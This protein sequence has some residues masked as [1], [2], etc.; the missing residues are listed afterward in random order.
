MYPS[1]QKST[2]VPS[3]TS[4]SNTTF[5]V[6]S[7]RKSFRVSLMTFK[8]CQGKRC[9][10]ISQIFSP[11]ISDHHN[12]KQY[13]LWQ[14]HNSKQILLKLVWHHICWQVRCHEKTE[15]LYQEGPSSQNPCLHHRQPER[16]YAKTVWQGKE[17][18]GIDKESA[19]FAQENPGFKYSVSD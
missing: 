5:T 10:K 4:S 11:A 14:K 2:L 15:W 12:W 9:P 17:E 8:I 19:S 7:L 18:K 1:V 3:G 16:W 13:Q 6:G